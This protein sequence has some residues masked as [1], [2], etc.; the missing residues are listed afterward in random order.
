LITWDLLRKQVHSHDHGSIFV[1]AAVSRKAAT[2]EEAAK[3][4]FHGWIS[5]FDIP[6]CLLSDRGSHFLAEL[7]KELL[8]LFCIK[9]LNTTAYDPQTNGKPERA[10]RTLV[11]MLMIFCKRADFRF[12][13]LGHALAESCVYLAHS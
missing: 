9:K 3:G 12:Q 4:L 8:K 13:R 5:N 6:E 10:H 7:M 1:I 11:P 2:A